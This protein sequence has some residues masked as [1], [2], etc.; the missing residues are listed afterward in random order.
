VGFVIV[1]FEVIAVAVAGMLH[2]PLTP[3]TVNDASSPAV[4][5]VARAP[6]VSVARVSNNRHGTIGTIDDAL[7]DPAS[8]SLLRPTAVATPA[9][10]IA[11]TPT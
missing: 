2:S 6:I 7:P 3:R 4:I 8:S 10:S 9:D 1:T 5:G 11:A